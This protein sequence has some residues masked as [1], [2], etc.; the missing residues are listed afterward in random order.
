MR[1]HKPEPALTS[2]SDYSTGWT[3]DESEVLFP[4]GTRDVFS[5][6]QTVPEIHSTGEIPLG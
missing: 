6:R 4:E 3:L 5:N 2:Y 1:K